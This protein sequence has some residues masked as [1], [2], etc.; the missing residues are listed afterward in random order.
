M[1]TGLP[2]LK[3]YDWTLYFAGVDFEFNDGMQLELNFTQ[4][5]RR[6][7]ISYETFA[8]NML[9]QDET[10]NLL[11]SVPTGLPRAFTLGAIPQAT[12]TIVDDDG[13]ECM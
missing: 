9:E 11:L 4:G 3:T 12:F 6:L 5:D 1:C 8:D 10:F 7:N 13:R 2:L